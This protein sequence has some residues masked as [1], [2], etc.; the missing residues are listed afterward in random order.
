[1]PAEA[2]AATTATAKI[3]RAINASL[4]DAMREHDDVVM[5]GQDVAGP[6]GPYGLTR[7]LLDEF[8][9]TRVRDT[10]ISEAALMGCAA[11]AAMAGLRPV[12]EI[13]FFDFIAL[14][15]DQLVNQAA[16]YRFYLGDDA[17]P[18]PLVVQTLYGGRAGMGAQHSQSLEAWLCHVPGLKV[19]F[20]AT[21]QDSYDVMRT[22]IAAPDPVV[23]IHSITALREQGELVTGSSWTEHPL[24]GSR[25]VRT[26]RA[27]TLVSYGPAV[28]ICEEA[29]ARTGADADLI[30]LRWLQPWDVEAVRASVRR[31]SRLLVVHEA[32]VPGGWGA[33]IVAR[34]AAEEFWHL[35]VPPVRVGADFSPLPVARRDWETMLPTV[36]RVC[37]AIQR[38]LAT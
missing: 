5:L 9:P 22:A 3:W 33:E 28:R 4:H 15:I 32:V 13:M 30:D 18:L 23:V 7:G 8:G 37:E 19:A 12:V 31:T 16:K 36:E 11:G 17:P 10:P 6:G 35:D 25:V 26:G 27:L 21:V 14:A 38:M 29:L 2:P 34:V 1:M 20:P 24:G